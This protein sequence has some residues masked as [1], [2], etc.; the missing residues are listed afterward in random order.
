MDTGRFAKSNFIPAMNVAETRSAL[1]VAALWPDGLILAAMHPNELQRYDRQIRLPEIGLEGQLRLKKA[2]VLVV[3]VG[4]LGSPASLYLAAAGVGQIGLI[5]DDVVSV[6]NLQR[7]ILF[8]ASQA[9]ERKVSAA[10]TRLLALNSE[11][12]IVEYPAALTTDNAVALFRDYDLIL[13]GTDNF[14]TRDLISRACTITRRP[15]VYAAIFKF[16]GQVAVFKPGVTACYRCLVPN[17]PESAEIPNC[18]ETGVL[19][20]LPGMIGSLQA[21]EALKLILNL[22]TSREVAKLFV[23]DALHLESRTLSVDRKIN[24]LGCGETAHLESLA[25]DSFAGSQSAFQIRADSLT[26]NSPEFNN[27]TVWIDVRSEAE[28]QKAHRPGA[29]NIPVTELAD[30]LSALDR[31][32]T[33]VVY[34]ASGQRSYS[35]QTLLLRQGFSTVWNLRGGLDF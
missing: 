16:E 24:C 10:R 20:A 27:R 12:N 33:Y 11:I 21:L 2:K 31:S 30:K 26:A 9:G 6:S 4:G 1:R 28:F 14:Q 32:Q 22:E 3:G 17:L 7:Q 8:E 13:D 35:A 29:L 23:F 15:H 18:S 34:C 25:K 5:D 19:G